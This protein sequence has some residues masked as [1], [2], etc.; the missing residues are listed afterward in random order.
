[1]LDGPINGNAFRTWVHQALLPVLQPRDIVVM[2]NFGSHKVAGV[3]AAIESAGAQVRYLP[4][5]SP[6][7]NP[8]EQVFAR[9]KMLL[10][11]TAARTMNGLWSDFGSMLDRFNADGCEE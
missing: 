11:K 2:D 5:C 6:D 4:P 10:R 3:A 8:I 9:L 1:M 7:Y